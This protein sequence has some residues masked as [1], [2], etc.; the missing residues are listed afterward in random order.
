MAKALL[1]LPPVEGGNLGLEE[2]CM[3]LLGAFFLL[4]SSPERGKGFRLLLGLSTWCLTGVEAVPALCL[5]V[6]SL[7]TTMLWWDAGHTGSC[8]QQNIL[9]L[10][11]AIRSF[12]V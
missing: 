2:G 9:L 4:V 12:N 6:S 1:P 11:P 7:D 3:I 8:S 10:L 5:A